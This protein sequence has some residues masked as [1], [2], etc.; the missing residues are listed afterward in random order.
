[1]ELKQFGFNVLQ[2]LHT[3]YDDKLDDLGPIIKSLY[4]LNWNV[5]VQLDLLGK[6]DN[7]TGTAIKNIHKDRNI[8]KSIST[9][10]AT[11]P[12]SNNTYERH[13]KMVD[14][15]TIID[16][17]KEMDYDRNFFMMG[18][19]NLQKMHQDDEKYSVVS[20]TIPSIPSSNKRPYIAESESSI[21]TTRATKGISDRTEEEKTSILMDDNITI[22]EEKEMDFDRILNVVNM[23][24]KSKVVLIAS[25]SSQNTN[26]RSIDF[27]REPSSLTSTVK[28]VD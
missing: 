21:S 5:L 24:H 19:A 9:S 14:D 20:T 23:R 10:R 22:D 7:S 27:S 3:L 25:S 28:Y 26:P 1:M 18:I 17:Q 12:V 11:K 15:N 8:E 16:E 6:I 2:S 4:H 13:Q